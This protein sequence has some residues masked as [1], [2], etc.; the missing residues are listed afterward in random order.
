MRVK[1][2]LFL[3]LLCLVACGQ[4]S[5]EVG[6]LKPNEL[7]VEF[8]APSANIAIPDNRTSSH[9]QVL[10]FGNS[11]LTLQAGLI[12]RLIETGRPSVEVYVINAGGGFLDDNLRNQSSV[13]LLESKPWTH[14]ILQGQKYS[15]SG[16][17]IYPTTAAQVW[18]D[19]AKSHG[20]TPILFPEH[21]QRG[22]KEE[23]RIVHQIHKGISLL[24]NSCVAP[25]GLAWDKVLDT[26]PQL[27][28]HQSDGNHASLIGSLLTALIF[29]E[30]ITGEPADLLPFISE[31]DVE[32]G[33]QQLLGQIASETI[34]ANQPCLF[35]E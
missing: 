1:Y 15:Q 31:L 22:N 29:Y 34:Q 19:K 6:E 13:T 17:R 9:Y 28:L 8:N 7:P 27:A 12:S 3:L 18:I 24:Q 11:H 32:E 35:G 33:T 20:I 4:D 16:T 5:T 2:S 23:G 10:L 25:V 30:V 21:P 14:V 26:T